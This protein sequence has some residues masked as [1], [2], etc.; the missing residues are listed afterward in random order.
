MDNDQF[1]Q[2]LEVFTISQR[3][4]LRQVNANSSIQQAQQQQQQQ[5]NQPPLQVQL[6]PFENFDESKENF[7]LYIQRFENYL[8]MKGA[9]T[10]RTLCQQ[11]FLNSIG[12]AHFR[13]LVSLVAPQNI[14]NVAYGELVK[15][16]ETH[17]CPR[18]NIL[19]IQ[20]RFLSTYQ[21]EEQTV[22]S[23]VAHLRRDIN[24]C[25]FVSACKCHADISSIFLR[26]QFIRGITDNSIRE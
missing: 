5:Q 2:L 3:E 4:L 1:K 18:K 23:Y 19:V 25:D 22:A 7:K 17:L 12:A 9:L 26:A 6:P 15:K 8:K 10:N 14:T 13:L 24:D 11:M 20:H 21:S 16:L